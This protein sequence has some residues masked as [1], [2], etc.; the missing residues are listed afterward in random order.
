MQGMW[1]MKLLIVRHAES[2]ANI[3]G[4]LQGQKIDTSLSKLGKEQAKKVGERLKDEKIEA[5]YSSDLKRAKETAEEIA[6]HHKLKVILDKRLR[7]KDHHNKEKWKEVVKRVKS[8]LK[9]VQKH[10][11][12]III[13]SHGSPNRIMLAIATEDRKKGGEL[14]KIVTQKN[15]CINI[16]ERKK[17]RYKIKLIDCIKHLK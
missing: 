17:G 12:N 14:I 10:K 13:V 2:K 5:V 4:I 16:I 7:E 6:K 3:K 1:E 11:G 8:F 9:D 15:T